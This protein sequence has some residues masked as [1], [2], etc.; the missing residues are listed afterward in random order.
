MPH[1]HDHQ[2]SHHQAFLPVSASNLAAELL[3]EQ[4]LPPLLFA[5]SNLLSV[6]DSFLVD[7]NG[8]LAAQRLNHLRAFADLVRAFRTRSESGP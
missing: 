6:T 4:V 2:H 7:Q 3:A 1:S 8:D 5:A